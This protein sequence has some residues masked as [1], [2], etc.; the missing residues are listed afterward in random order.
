MGLSRQLPIRNLSAM[1]GRRFR[2]RRRLRHQP[3]LRLCAPARLLSPL[4]TSPCGTFRNRARDQC[5][6]GH[7]MRMAAVVATAAVLKL[8]DRVGLHSRWSTETPF[9]VDT[10]VSYMLH[11]RACPSAA[12]AGRA[13]HCAL[14][15]LIRP[16]VLNRRRKPWTD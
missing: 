12:A 6:R 13:E 11:R 5:P 4:L 14:P 2:H 10:G 3:G 1:P 9:S 16:R 8:Q 7:D 15:P